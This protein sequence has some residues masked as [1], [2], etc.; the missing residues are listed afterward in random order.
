MY[1]NLKEAVTELLNV[2]DNEAHDH[3]RHFKGDRDYTY[4]T[5]EAHIN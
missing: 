5:A 3:K 1:K 2:A 4:S